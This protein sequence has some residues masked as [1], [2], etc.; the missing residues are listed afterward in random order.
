MRKGMERLLVDWTSY[1]GISGNRTAWHREVVLDQY[2]ELILQRQSAR[3][4]E[5]GQPYKATCNIA[6][7]IVRLLNSL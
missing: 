4:L 2:A 3:E 5:D 7:K 6:T 1:A